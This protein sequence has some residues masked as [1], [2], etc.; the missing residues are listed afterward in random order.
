[1]ELQTHSCCSDLLCSLCHCV[2]HEH[3]L[4]TYIWGWDEV[5]GTALAA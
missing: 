4:H 2:L 5:V 1:M 3:V